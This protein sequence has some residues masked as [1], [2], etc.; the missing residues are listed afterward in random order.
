MS[1][2]DWVTLFLTPRDWETFGAGFTVFKRLVKRRYVERRGRRYRLTSDGAA[3]IE[4]YRQ[5][6]WKKFAQIEKVLG[7]IMTQL[8]QFPIREDFGTW[9][10][11][12]RKP[13]P[14]PP[15]PRGNR[16]HREVI[17]DLKPTWAVG[18]RLAVYDDVE[19]RMR[20]AVVTTAKLVHPFND[21]RW[22]DLPRSTIFYIFMFDDNTTIC[23]YEESLRSMVKG[24]P[25]PS[26]IGL[27][28][29]RA[30][31]QPAA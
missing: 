30:G 16:R 24:A 4:R 23:G 18:T 12:G 15:K 11:I 27:A 28:P 5:E 20:N 8:L 13:D 29:T 21:G 9:S 25:A 31:Q 2:A 26:A 3:E 14:T 22:C 1:A 10:S 7:Q 17:V 6:R 19:R